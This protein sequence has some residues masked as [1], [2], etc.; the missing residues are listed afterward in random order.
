MND[1]F[2]NDTSSLNFK[3][4]ETV[5]KIGAASIT[6]KLKDNDNP[7]G[8]SEQT[9]SYYARMD[10]LVAVYGDDTTFDELEQSVTEA[11][12]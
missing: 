3:K 4:A 6:L 5:R 2:E 9:Q 11:I 12:G 1:N 10:A 8:V 7:G